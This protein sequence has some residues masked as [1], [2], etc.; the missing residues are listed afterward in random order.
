MFGIILLN[1]RTY[2]S[3]QNTLNWCFFFFHD[4]FGPDA[5]SQFQFW[6]YILRSD[7]K[8]E[9]T[10]TITEI[11]YYSIF[12]A[13]NLH[14]FYA[15]YNKRSWQQWQEMFVSIPK[16]QMYF[17]CS[18]VECSHIFCIIRRDNLIYHADELFDLC[19]PMIYIYT[20]EENV[21]QW[22]ILFRCE[23]FQVQ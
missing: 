1:A 23:Y 9:A 12:I 22:I 8:P 11:C 14:V 15:R 4:E 2:K 5:C 20:M 7:K 16:C 6:L 19:F 13:S 18:V 21:E 3:I 10:T 17:R